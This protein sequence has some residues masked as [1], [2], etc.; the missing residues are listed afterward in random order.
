MDPEPYQPPFKPLIGG[1]Q[2][3][4]GG[5][6]FSPVATSPPKQSFNLQIKIWTTKNQWSF[7]QSVFYSVR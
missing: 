7:H 4:T 6:K 3:V 1:G 5:P 2:A